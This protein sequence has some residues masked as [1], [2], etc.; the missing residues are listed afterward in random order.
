M[1]FNAK[2]LVDPLHPKTAAGF[3]ANFQ[4]VR[5]QWGQDGE[6]L[7]EVQL[8]IYLSDYAT[9]RCQMPQGTC[10][11]IRSLMQ[12]CRERGIHVILRFALEDGS[13][14]SALPTTVQDVQA[15]IDQVAPIVHEYSDVTTIWQAGFIGTWGEWGHDVHEHRNDPNAIWAIMKTLLL[16]LPDGVDTQMRYPW[17][18]DV[19][20]KQ[21]ALDRTVT[22]EQQRDW[23]ARI[24]IHNDYFTPGLNGASGGDDVLDPDSSFLKAH[25]IEYA[26]LVNELSAVPVEGEMPWD[27]IQ[28]PND[29]YWTWKQVVPAS[30][31]AVRMCEQGYTTFSLSHNYKL[32]YPQWKRKTWTLSDVRAL[33]LPAQAAYFEDLH[34]NECQRTQYEYIRDHL[35]YRLAMNSL[36]AKVHDGMLAISLT[37]V[38]YGFTAPLK[39]YPVVLSLFN[40]RWDIV[41]SSLLSNVKAS[42]WFGSSASAIPGVRSD[43]VE[44]TIKG[45]VPLSEI[46]CGQYRLVLTIGDASAVRG[47]VQVANT[48]VEFVRG[49]NVLAEV[50]IM[51]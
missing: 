20:L 38:N 49:H 16:N 26:T 23:T 4:R 37:L 42:E 33:H 9:G 25:N 10:A 7:N 22:A 28:D 14:F 44:H 3:E 48:D 27:D 6:Q 39:N 5:S 24:G 1:A 2:T 8:Y 51:P 21:C 50:R 30:S 19:A 41:A 40:E 17:L 35:G 13:Y 34:G 18:R 47:S 45:A 43:P 31:A 29:P 12:C 11:N 32:T 36:Q 46:S 15:L